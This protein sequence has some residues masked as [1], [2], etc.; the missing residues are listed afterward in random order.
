MSVQM[1]KT[2]NKTVHHTNTSLLKCIAFCPGGMEAVLAQDIKEI[3]GKSCEQRTHCCIFE[4]TQQEIATFAY[5]CQSIERVGILL[6]ST[7]PDTLSFNLANLPEIPSTFSLSCTVH[8][9][10]PFTSQDIVLEVSDSIRK[11]TGKH[12]TYK[13]ADVLFGV[14]ICIDAAYL[15]VHLSRKDIVKRDYKVFVH[16]MSLRGPVAYGLCRIAGVKKGETVLDPFC[17]SGEVLI[18]LG[19]HLLGRSLHTYAKDKFIWETL[20]WNVSLEDTEEKAM[21][22]LYCYDAQAPNVKAAEKNAKIAGIN[23]SLNFSRVLIEDLDLKFDKNIDRIITQLPPAGK[24][25]ERLTAKVCE[26]L[27]RQCALI[28]RDTGTIT[29]LGRNIE[30]ALALAEQAGLSIIHKQE[31]EQ[32]K[33]TVYVFSAKVASR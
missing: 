12:P 31:I 14:E 5:T 29:C 28:L 18:E 32:G 21:L 17:R 22:P 25:T 7:K 2:A 9:G 24:E 3:C 11:A 30:G 19:H 16:K 10:L 23:R 15:F 13:Q 27:F 4:G 20:G 26:R 1:M 6:S 33:E 8:N